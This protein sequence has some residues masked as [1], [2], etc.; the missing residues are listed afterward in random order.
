MYDKKN[1][2]FAASFLPNEPVL[3]PCDA[4]GNTLHEGDRVYT[5][6]INDDND[7]YR[8]YGKLIKSEEPATLGHWCIE[9]DDGSCFIVLQWGDVWSTTKKNK[10]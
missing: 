5:H 1:E 10:I 8:C 9:Y 3:I 2:N 6:D 4:T 7:L